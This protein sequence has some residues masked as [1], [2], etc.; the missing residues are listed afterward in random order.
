MYVGLLNKIKEASNKASRNELFTR[1]GAENPE[2]DDSTED[3]Y[4]KQGEDLLDSNKTILTDTLDRVHQ[5]RQIGE[6]GVDKLRAQNEQL[7]RIDDSLDQM[8]SSLDV[9]KRL[10]RQI[11]TRIA[12]DKLLWVMILLV[13]IAIVVLV[14][15]TRMI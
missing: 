10:I 14:I 5:A 7:G 4:I 8:S 11:A 6:S 3:K 2:D 13:V 1:D 15:L 9:S 12:T